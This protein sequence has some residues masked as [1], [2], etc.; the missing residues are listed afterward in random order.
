MTVTE[1]L[2]E[3]TIR[4]RD[5]V[6]RGSSEQVAM[7]LRCLSQGSQGSIGAMGPAMAIHA[8]LGVLRALDRPGATMEATRFELDE[9]MTS[10][11]VTVV[12]GKGRYFS[13]KAL[14]HVAQTLGIKT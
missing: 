10:I 7:L 11:L 3:F 8:Y 12:V 2:E 13:A 1:R 4:V 6:E 9:D 14:N 5:V